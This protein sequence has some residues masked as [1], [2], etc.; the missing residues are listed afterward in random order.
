M[1]LQE[2]YGMIGGDYDQ[3]LRVLR[4]DKLVDKHIRKFEQNGTVAELLAAGEDMNPRRLF[5]SAHA[6]KG[7]SANLGLVRLSESASRITEE[8]R[9]GNERKMTDDEVRALLDSV[10][11]QYEKTVEGIRLYSE[12]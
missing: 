10:R 11:E 1:T 3:A 4:M 9:P 6:L 2:L 8:Y 7:I 5:E 12:G